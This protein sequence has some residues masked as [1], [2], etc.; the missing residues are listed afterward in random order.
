MPDMAINPTKYRIMRAAAKLYADRGYDAVTIREIGKIADIN[1]STIYFHFKSKKDILLSLYEYFHER[2]IK[3]YPVLDELLKQAETDPPIDVLMNAM[4]HFSD[5]VRE[6]LDQILVTGSRLIVSDADN[7]R[8]IRENIFDS[9]TG[10]LRPLLERLVELGRIEPLDI[11]TLLGIFSYYCF[12]AAAL[13]NSPFK[14][15]PSEYYNAVSFMFSSF[16]KPTGG[17]E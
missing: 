7:E 3:A 1:P 8:F 13:N 2:Q 16:I 9:V 15:G 10:T 14:Q 11:D 5:D 12:S 4:F 17:V 6:F